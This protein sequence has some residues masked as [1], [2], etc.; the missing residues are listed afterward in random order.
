[1]YAD[2]CVPVYILGLYFVWMNTNPFFAMA[3]T[4]FGPEYEYSM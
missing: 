4:S 3:S 1:M 2:E